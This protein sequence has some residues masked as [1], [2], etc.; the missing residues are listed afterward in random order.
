MFALKVQKFFQ[1]IGLKSFSQNSED[2][3]LLTTKSNA[4][5]ETT[6]YRE[7]TKVGE[8]FLI[9]AIKALKVFG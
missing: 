6:L 5:T 9:I 3:K 8:C 1:K 7:N 4:R 2:P